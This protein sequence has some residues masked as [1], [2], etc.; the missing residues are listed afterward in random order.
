MNASSIEVRKM[1]KIRKQY[2]LT[3]DT[4]QE[5]NKNTTNTS[6]KSQ[7]FPPPAG[8]HMAAMN[9]RESIRNTKHKWSTKEALPRNG[10]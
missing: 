1:A 6:Y 9:R 10:Q 4:T 8:D 7:A 5:S 3:Q 2:N